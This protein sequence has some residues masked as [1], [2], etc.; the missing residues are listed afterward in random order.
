M[1]ATQLLVV[2][3]RN[4]AVLIE[5]LANVPSQI[6]LLACSAELLT[7]IRVVVFLVYLFFVS[8]A[9]RDRQV[10]RMMHSN[11]VWRVACGSPYDPPIL[12]RLLAWVSVPYDALTML[13]SVEPYLLLFVLVSLHHTQSTLLFQCDRKKP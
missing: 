11:S 10:L 6:Y 3:L 7:V 4:R 8:Y 12:S 9:S 13:F 1:G 2:I 5:L